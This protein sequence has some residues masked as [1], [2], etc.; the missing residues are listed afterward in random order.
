M[1][2][3]GLLSISQLKDRRGA[4][5]SGEEM[6]REVGE[7]EGGEEGGMLS[8]EQSTAHCLR[9]GANRKRPA[10]VARLPDMND[11]SSRN[12]IH[13]TIFTLVMV[14]GMRENVSLSSY[15]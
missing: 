5:A 1:P 7:E 2:G 12:Y 8:H 3:P 15:I 13:V 9:R 4:C 10:R 14:F 11:I 6:R